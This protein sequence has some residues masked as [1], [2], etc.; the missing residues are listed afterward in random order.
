MLPREL[1]EQ[2]ERETLSPHACKS[3]ETKGRERPQPL[4][5]IRTEF[6]RDRD[7]IIH[8]NAFRRL[9]H[10]TQVFL[11]PK[12]DHY[13]TRLTHTLEVA[14]I[15][16]TIA[17]A[18]RLNEDLT[19]AIALGHDLGHTPFGHDGERMLNELYSGGFKH[20]EQSVRVVE[21]IEREGAGLNLTAEVRN[22][23]LCHTNLTA[24]TLE[25]VAVKFADK[26]AYINHDIEDAIRGGVL[27]QKDLPELPVRVLGETKSE[28]ITS[29]VRSLI[30]NSMGK[31]ELS[32]DSPTK[33]AHDE[34]REFMF[35]NVY[36][37][38]ATNREKDKA[39]FII[40]YLYRFYLKNPEKLPELYRS[41]ARDETVERAVCDYISC[42]TD[43]FAID[44]FTE[45]CI[46][47]PWITK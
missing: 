11:I 19:E 23:I 3:A 8:S 36:Y 30:D 29:L 10:K 25:G 6:Q 28:R 4:C 32:Y 20:Y 47:R 12:S 9:K 14:Q 2:I 33:Q 34:L 24:D 44:T 18:L 16:R 43:D 13:R 26:I 37:A 31:P 21:R 42:M 1:T 40:D 27:R 15:A 7:R 17:R 35:Q 22:G 5:D 45:H 38:D 39:C 41:I 46:P